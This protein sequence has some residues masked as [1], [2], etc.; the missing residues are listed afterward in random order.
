MKSASVSST[1][2]ALLAGLAAALLLQAPGARAAD[3]PS[4]RGAER[5]GVQQA[6]GAFVRAQTAG[7]EWMLHY[8]PVQGKLV[9]LKLVELHEG[10]VNKGHF[11]VSC[12][13]FQD[14]DQR[15]YDLD[16][17]VVPTADGNGFRVNQAIVHAVDGKKRKVHVEQ[18]WPG[19]F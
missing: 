12:A 14:E 13:D 5:T 6:M 11:F 16:F 7:G 1:P 19:I 2:K 4:I 15:T 18:R 8:D 10:I 17:L 9:R 3:D